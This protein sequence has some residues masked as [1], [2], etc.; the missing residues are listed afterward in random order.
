MFYHLSSTGG[1]KQIHLVKD[2]IR[3]LT[4]E[5]FLMKIIVVENN[6][7]WKDSTAA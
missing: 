7:I 3:T 4:V 6:C 1:R 2:H 5:N